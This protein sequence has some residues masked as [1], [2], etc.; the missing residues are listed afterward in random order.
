MPFHGGIQQNLHDTTHTT[1]VP[2]EVGFEICLG[3]GVLL[4]LAYQSPH[5]RDE[6]FLSFGLRAGEPF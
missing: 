3:D 5:A 1:Y 6:V 2:G 4:L